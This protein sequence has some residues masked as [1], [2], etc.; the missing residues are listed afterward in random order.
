MIQMLSAQNLNL[1]FY[2][3]LSKSQIFCHYL[4]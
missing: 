1:D 2:S 3:S 4:I